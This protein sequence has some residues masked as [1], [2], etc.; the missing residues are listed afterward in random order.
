MNVFEFW[1]T[2][3]VTEA[4]GRL[5]DKSLAVDVGANVGTWIKP[6]S[7]LFDHVLAF[8]PDERNFSVLEPSDN[9]TAVRAAVTDFTGETPFYIRASS[10]HN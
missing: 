3:P 4:I 6:L 8:E 9:V 1:L 10:G 5:G 2:Q 7:E